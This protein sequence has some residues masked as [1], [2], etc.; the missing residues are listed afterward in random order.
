[1]SLAKVHTGAHRNRL[2]KEQTAKKMKPA[3][4][5]NSPLWVQWCWK[6]IADFSLS[7][8]HSQ[9]F[10]LKYLET[11]K[12][13]R[14]FQTIRAFA[15]LRQQKPKLRGGQCGFHMFWFKESRNKMMHGECLSTR[16]V[17]QWVC[18]IKIQM[19]CAYLKLLLKFRRGKNIIG[20]NETLKSMWL[21]M[22]LKS[23]FCRWLCVTEQGHILSSPAWDFLSS[24]DSNSC[25]YVWLPF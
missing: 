2:W 18:T 9:G 16:P 17:Y 6:R 22:Y 5:W 20:P 15:R 12:I 11:V 21:W 7:V 14:Q 25:Q 8:F 23:F 10:P 4:M 24:A 19:H 13:N 3:C 1:M